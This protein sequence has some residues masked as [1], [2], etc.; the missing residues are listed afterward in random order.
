MLKQKKSYN[1]SVVG[2]SEIQENLFSSAKGE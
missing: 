2:A 1:F